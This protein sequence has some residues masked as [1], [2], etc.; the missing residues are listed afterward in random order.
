MEMGK[1]PST[2]SIYISRFRKLYILLLFISFILILQQ[3]FPLRLPELIFIL[4]GP[5]ADPNIG[6]KMILIET[7]FLYSLSAIISSK[8]RPNDSTT[9]GRQF[10]I[11][12]LYGIYA[13]ALVLMNLTY[14]EIYK[15]GWETLI[16]FAAIL[17]SVF[18]FLYRTLMYEFNSVY[19]RVILRFNAILSLFI[20]NVVILYFYNYFVSIFGLISSTFFLLIISV[21]IHFITG[22]F[23]YPYCRN[24]ERKYIVSGTY[25]AISPIILISTVLP[26]NSVYNFFNTTSVPVFVISFLIFIISVFPISINYFLFRY[27]GPHFLFSNT[28]GKFPKSFI[29]VSILLIFFSFL[30]IELSQSFYIFMISVTIFLSLVGLTIT[31]IASNIFLENIKSQRN[32]FISYLIGITLSFLLINT[33]TG[34]FFYSFLF[35]SFLNKFPTLIHINILYIISIIKPIIPLVVFGIIYSILFS[36]PFRYTS[37]SKYAFIPF[38]IFYMSQNYNFLKFFFTETDSFSIFLLLI[39][40]LIVGKIS[41]IECRLLLKSGREKGDMSYKKL[42]NLLIQRGFDLRGDIIKVSPSMYYNVIF[43]GYDSEMSKYES[44]SNKRTKMRNLVFKNYKRTLL[45]L[46]QMKFFNSLSERSY[47]KFRIESNQE[48]AGILEK[49]IK[50]EDF[51]ELQEHNENLVYYLSRYD[52]KFKIGLYNIVSKKSNLNEYNNSLMYAFTIECKY[53]IDQNLSKSF[54]NAA[55]KL[56]SSIIQNRD[57]KIP[58]PS[59]FIFLMDR[60]WKENENSIY[61]IEF[62]TSRL[63]NTMRIISQQFSSHSVSFFDFDYYEDVEGKKLKISEKEGILDIDYNP[64]LHYGTD[65]FWRWVFGNIFIN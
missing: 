2:S 4:L 5:L 23:L 15:E 63:K 18:Q 30:L 39:L 11:F 65:L 56:I 27:A 12:Y 25:L 61:T 54:D 29:V 20:I 51:A 53:L 37:F 17:I 16:Y 50:N 33:I 34:G 13:T 42:Y 7:I 48:N 49:I 9:M 10:F 31:S 22:I 59:I 46:L 19:T 41:Q 14:P 57:V 32:F 45:F 62:F 28:K 35:S 55:S 64:E 60:T 36:I 40:V 3:N 6:L 52:G 24:R 8:I 38:V 21:L 44:D 58:K 47:E 1:L 43:F 26:I